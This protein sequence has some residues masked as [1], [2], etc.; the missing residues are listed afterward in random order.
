[1][2]TAALATRLPVDL[3]RAL[4]EVCRQLGFRKNHVLEVALREK[5]EDLLDS[6]DLRQAVESSTGFH[7]WEAVRKASARGRP[8]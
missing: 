6:E 1:M 4:D 8:K 3:I 2:K 5:I 7:S